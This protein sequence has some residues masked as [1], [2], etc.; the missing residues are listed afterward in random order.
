MILMRD[1]NP[2]PHNLISIVARRWAAG[3]RSLCRPKFLYSAIPLPRVA[4]SALRLLSLSARAVLFYFS[5]MR[6]VQPLPLSRGYREGA[7]C[8]RCPVRPIFIPLSRLLPRVFSSVL[9][10]LCF[11]PSNVERGSRWLLPIPAPVFLFLFSLPRGTD[12]FLVQSF[13]RT[14]LRRLHRSLPFRRERKNT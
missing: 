12:L 6:N 14:C 13:G 3:S 5:L 4:P 2:A 9:F 11:A 10:Y 7:G 8:A 1:E